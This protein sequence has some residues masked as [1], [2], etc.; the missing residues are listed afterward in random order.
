LVG[1]VDFESPEEAVDAK[2]K[3]NGYHVSP[4]DERSI[5]SILIAIIEDIIDPDGFKI[6]CSS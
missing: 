1:F 2:D 4:D 6:V 5:L 3:Y